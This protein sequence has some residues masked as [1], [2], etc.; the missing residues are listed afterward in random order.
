[1]SQGSIQGR[2]TKNQKPKG[3]LFNKFGNVVLCQNYRCIDFNPYIVKRVI[4]E[5]S[6]VGINQSR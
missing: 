4:P 3:V 6:S 5:N 2:F 1:M